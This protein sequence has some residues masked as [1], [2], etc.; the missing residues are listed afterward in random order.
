VLIEIFA[1][2]AAIRE[3]NVLTL[4]VCFSKF[5]NIQRTLE[6]SATG[7]LAELNHGPPQLP[8]LLIFLLKQMQLRPVKIAANVFI[9]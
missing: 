3:T 2:K 4:D 5:N 1:S 7:F 9:V 6:R 8:I